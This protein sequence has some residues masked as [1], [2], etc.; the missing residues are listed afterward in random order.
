MNEQAALREAAV[1]LLARREHARRE[2]ADKLTRRGWPRDRVE[3]VLDQLSAEGLQ[4]DARFAE[5]FTRQRAGRCYGPLRIRSELEN[6]GIDR[7]LIA[8]TLGDIDADWPAI[9]H[10]WYRK[11]Y[12]GR[13]PDSFAEKAR[14]M[15][16]LARRGF[17]SEHFRDLFE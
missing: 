16:T 12:R 10:Q 17:A 11:H 1:R 15:Q 4:S 2:L 14:R 9:A 6:R 7:Q 3:T 13:A 5:S 8:R